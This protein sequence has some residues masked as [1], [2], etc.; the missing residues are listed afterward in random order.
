MVRNAAAALD[1]K[2]SDHV[3]LC[4]MAKL[5][6]TENCTDVSR[7]LGVYN[8]T[9]IDEGADYWWWEKYEWIN[10]NLKTYG[11]GIMVSNGAK[12]DKL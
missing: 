9:L 5:F 10:D 12:M 11:N 2:T 1:A 4:A 6:A 7:G 3:A 8:P